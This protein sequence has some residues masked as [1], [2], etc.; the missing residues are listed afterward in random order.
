[1]IRSLRGKIKQHKDYNVIFRESYS[2]F[3]QASKDGHRIDIFAF[4]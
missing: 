4:F 3:W 2:S 1:M